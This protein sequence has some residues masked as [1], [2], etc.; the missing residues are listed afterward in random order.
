MK[1]YVGSLIG[2]DQGN[3]E[4]FSDF[5]N[6]GEMWT[7]DGARERRKPVLF[8]E[9]F[10]SDPTVQVSLSLWD[11]DQGANVRADIAAENI[12]PTGFDLVF[13]TWSD[14]RVARVRMSWTAI[15]EV[16]SEDDW[17]LY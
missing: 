12:T 5:A 7:G 17:E 3:D 4:V 11:M 13:R 2:V 8:S 6:G 9:P 14:T 15:G 16:R 1:K 10:L